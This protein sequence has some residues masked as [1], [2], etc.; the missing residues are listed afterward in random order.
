M[1]ALSAIS[2]AT[3][4]ALERRRMAARLDQLAER[5]GVGIDVLEDFVAGVAPGRE[6]AVERANIGVAKRH[7]LSARLSDQ[8]F[9]VVVQDDRHI[10]ARQ[11]HRGLDRDPVGRHVGGEQRVP[12]G[13]GALVPDIEQRDFLAQQERR[14][15]SCEVTVDVVMRIAREGWRRAS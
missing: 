14:R 7:K 9:T 10:L 2:E 15:M 6:P 4:S 8:P 3:S 11:P 12:G 1:S 13:E 5:L